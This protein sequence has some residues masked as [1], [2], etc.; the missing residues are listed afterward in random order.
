MKI[1]IEKN[2]LSLRECVNTVK[3]LNIKHPRTAEFVCYL[4]IKVYRYTWVADWISV[5]QIEV[6]E[7]V[8]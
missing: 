8:I 6:Y 5:Q 7:Y 4:E 1:D 3:F 2:F